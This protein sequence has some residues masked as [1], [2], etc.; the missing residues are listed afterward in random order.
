MAVQGLVVE[1]NDKIEVFKQTHGRKDVVIRF[2]N[3]RTV[4][5]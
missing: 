3:V 5:F 4:I 2:D 1:G